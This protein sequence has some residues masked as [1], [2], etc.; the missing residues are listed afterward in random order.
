MR[1]GQ[2]SPKGLMKSYLA[3]RFRPLVHDRVERL[4]CSE[5]PF[6]VVLAKVQSRRLLEPLVPHLVPQDGDANEL[7]AD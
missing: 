5:H 6:D 7:V 4:E 1:L 2:V 3:Q